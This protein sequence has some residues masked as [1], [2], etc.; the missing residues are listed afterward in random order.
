MIINPNITWHWP[1]CSGGDVI[2]V[3]F[4]G[5]PQIDVTN[6]PDELHGK[7][8]TDDSGA[9][10]DKAQGKAG[11]GAVVRRLLGT[12][13][14]GKEFDKEFGKVGWG[15]VVTTEPGKVESGPVF[16][17][18]PA[19]WWHS[20]VRHRWGSGDAHSATGLTVN[21]HITATP[22]APHTTTTTIATT[23]TTTPSA[24]HTTT[25]TIATTTTTTTT[26]SASDDDDDDDD[27]DDISTSKQRQRQ[28]QQQ[29]QQ[30]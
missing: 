11:S 3:L 23:T 6:P 13:Y 5:Q 14:S 15:A 20:R 9:V 16:E 30:H 8:S 18:L 27:D 24:P 19:Y 22:S 2:C 1:G 10:V 29:Q 25:T 21:D 26:L 12:A 28:Q 7:V 4:S 17:V